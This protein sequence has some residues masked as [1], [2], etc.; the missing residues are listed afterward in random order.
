VAA[1]GRLTLVGVAGYEGSIVAP[2]V[3][4]TL[5][6]A[7]AFCDRLGAL[8]A[9]L[10]AQGRFDGPPIVTAGGSAYFDAVA[11]ALSGV[12]DWQLVLRSGCYV[13]HDHGLYHRI[14]AFERAP[15]GPQLRP[16][17]TVHASVLSR[18]ERGTAVVG[19]GRRDISFDAGLP[20]LL[21]ATRGA[22][23]LDAHGASV[24]R[25]FDQHLVLTVTEDSPLR[26]GDEV[27]LGIS[28]PCTTFDKW[29]WLPVLDDEDR[30]VDVIRT[31]F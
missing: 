29:R 6:A 25:L 24:D 21:A 22:E 11:E 5:S 13:A 14:S 3:A 8:A 1:A 23:P 16:A 17:L 28:H 12:T 7:R 26:P 15:G 30:T 9:D 31:F 10:I 4:E 19:V 27:T 2:T 20:V 18:P